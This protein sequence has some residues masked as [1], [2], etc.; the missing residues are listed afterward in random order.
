MVNNP[1]YAAA[2]NSV[3]ILVLMVYVI[4]I[5]SQIQKIISIRQGT[6]LHSV[7]AIFL[8]MSLFG[9]CANSYALYRSLYVYYSGNYFYPIKENLNL[10]H[11]SDRFGMLC[12]TAV[13][14]YASVAIP[15]IVKSLLMEI[16]RL[17]ELLR[18]YSE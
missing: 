14:W 1:N 3:N 4:M 9:V 17:K 16:E 5:Y 18:R 12:K 10:A 7:Y 6:A 15:Y 8:T 13:L 11:F 2:I